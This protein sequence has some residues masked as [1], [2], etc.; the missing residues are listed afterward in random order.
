MAEEDIHHELRQVHLGP[1]ME[2]MT[3]TMKV[4]DPLST[5]ITEMA[6]I[7][8]FLIVDIIVE[9]YCQLENTW[10]QQRYTLGLILLELWK[11]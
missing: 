4:T 2:E 9:E 3:V 6:T 11:Q 8:E 1:Q 5:L 7:R 10:F